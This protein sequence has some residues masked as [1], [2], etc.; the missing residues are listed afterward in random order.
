MH[1][2]LKAEPWIAAYVNNFTFSWHMNGDFNRCDP[3]PREYGTLLDMPFIDRGALWIET[4]K[5]FG[6]RK[7]RVPPEHEEYQ[8]GGT[9]YYFVLDDES[10]FQPGIVTRSETAKRRLHRTQHPSKIGYGKTSKHATAADGPDGEGPDK[11]IKNVSDFNNCATELMVMLTPTLV[12]FEWSSCISHMPTAVFENLKA[13]SGIK[14]LGLLP[15][16]RRSPVD[17]RE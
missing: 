16:I 12:E 5:K 14:I 6:L 1:E 8:E 11:R 17:L 9:R 7:E 3:Y 13:G 4:K 15:R 2:Y 10:Y